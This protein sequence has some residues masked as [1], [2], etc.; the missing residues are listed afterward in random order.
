MHRH[1]NYFICVCHHQNLTLHKVGVSKLDSTNIL[2][3]WNE[4]LMSHR[5]V[6]EIV[7][8]TLRVICHHKNMLFG[9][10]LIVS[11][12]DFRQILPIVTKES[13]ANLIAASL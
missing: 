8:R 3:I 9:G 12:D 10:K 11:G 1:L 4:A 5:W 13:R 2:T 7:D 6:I